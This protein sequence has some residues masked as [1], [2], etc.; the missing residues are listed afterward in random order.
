MQ[1]ALAGHMIRQRLAAER[2]AILA[3]RALATLGI[4]R[5]PC[6][7]FAVL[8]HP[9]FKLPKDELQLLDLAVELLGG[10]AEP[11]PS[12]HRKLRLEMLDLKRLGIELGIADRNHAI[13]FDQ[14]GFLLGEQRFLL[15][16]GPLER[17]YIVGGIG[18]SACHRNN[19]NQSAYRT[20][21]N[22]C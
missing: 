12:Q 14:K 19:A 20:L 3:L 2:L 7:T 13:T 18:S 4:R 17:S 15:G 6:R 11:R 9:L 22:P 16:Q 8:R 1:H 5:R 10:A 21:M